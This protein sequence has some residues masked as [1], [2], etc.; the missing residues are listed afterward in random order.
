M[1][2]VEGGEALKCRDV[3]YNAAAY[4]HTNEMIDRTFGM[5]DPP[6]SHNRGHDQRIVK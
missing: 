3:A 2:E 6:L 4:P 1:G 5:I